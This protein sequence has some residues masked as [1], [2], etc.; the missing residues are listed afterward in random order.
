MIPENVAGLLLDTCA[1]HHTAA[2]LGEL[3][4]SNGHVMALPNRR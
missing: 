4:D 3:G 2:P 1:A